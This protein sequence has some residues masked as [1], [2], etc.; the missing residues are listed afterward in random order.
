MTFRRLLTIAGILVLAHAAWNRSQAADETSGG[1]LFPYAYAVDDLPNGLRLVTVPTDYPNMVALYVVVRA[2]S[3][4]EVEPGKSGYAHL[5]E[6]LMF[7]GSENYT[8]EQ[9][10]ALMKRAGAD[11]NASTN[12]DRTTYYAVFSKEDLDEVMKV[13]AD[14]FQRLKYTE[15]AYKTESLAVLG[16]YNKNSSE[17]TQKLDE[18]LYETAF[19]THTY[20]HTTMGYL[21]DVQDMP[22]QFAYSL[23]F[24]KRFYRPEYATVLLVGD[25][26]RERA[27]ELTKKYFGGW[28]HGS[29]APN[30]PAEPAQTGSRT[31]HVDWPSPTLPWLAVAF[32]GPAYSDETKDKAALDLLSEIAFGR[33]SDLYRRLVLEQQKV[34]ELGVDFGNHPDPELF[35]AYARIKDGKD[36]DDVREQVL[37]TF[38]RFTKETVDQ[39]KLDATRSRMRYS[40]ALRMNSSPAIAAALAPYILLRRTPDTINKVFALYQQ[41][42][43]QD[44]RSMA[45]KYLT[46]TNR[47]IVTLAT[48]T[49]TK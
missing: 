39:T 19:K 7:R 22:N 38:A 36:V 20:A 40:F 15:P 42:T 35:T 48:K 18:V 3:G 46:E 9:R 44:I 2:G 8:S 37:A 12:Q 28:A 10:D 41:V 11:T 32:K 23:D 24:Y 14:R 33:N 26:T 21:K 31:A 47:T 6:H 34:D 4:D 29:Y 17:P 25:V 45:A 27:L 16:E 1:K 5:F 30:I 13:E 43:P 49:G